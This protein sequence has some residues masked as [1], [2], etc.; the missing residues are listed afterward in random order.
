M[1]SFG[2]SSYSQFHSLMFANHIQGFRS[3]SFHRRAGAERRGCSTVARPCAMA[4]SAPAA[5]AAFS[6]MA[7]PPRV[8]QSSPPETWSLSVPSPQHR[9][10]MGIRRRQRVAPKRVQGE[11]SAGSWGRGGE[12]CWT[13]RHSPPGQRCAA[14]ARARSRRRRQ[15]RCPTDRAGDRR[16]PRTTPPSAR[17]RRRRRRRTAAWPHHP[18]GWRRTGRRRRQQQ[19]TIGGSGGR[20]ARG[21]GWGR[22][23]RS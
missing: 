3:S 14:S 22:R 8:A 11:R 5:T 19:T 1:N 23:G 17:R 7:P 12:W 18:P 9:P 15:P 2:R 21:R 16:A 6:S 10:W 4:P 13:A 20:R